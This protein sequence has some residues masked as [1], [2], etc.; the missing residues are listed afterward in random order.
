MTSEKKWIRLSGAGEFRGEG[1]WHEVR[2]A[3]ME[4][5]WSDCERTGFL[6]V[7]KTVAGREMVHTDQQPPRTPNFV[8]EDGWMVHQFHEVAV[9]INGVG[10]Q[11]MQHAQ[12]QL[13]NLIKTTL[14]IAGEAH[15]AQA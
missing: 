12:R 9:K 10:D 5:D 14:E 2:G 3:A 4:R 1:S 6:P 13:L 7:A 8:I 11:A 15:A